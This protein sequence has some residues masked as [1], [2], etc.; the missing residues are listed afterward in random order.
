M[1]NPTGVQEGIQTA[2]KAADAKMADLLD[3]KFIEVDGGA[4]QNDVGLTNEQISAATEKGNGTGF[5]VGKKDISNLAGGQW[6]QNQMES[7]TKGAQNAATGISTY[8]QATET[9]KR[10]Y[11]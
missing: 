10:A 6:F 8:K 11:Q 7:V 5:Y 3:M 1:S 4:V 9:V 2:L